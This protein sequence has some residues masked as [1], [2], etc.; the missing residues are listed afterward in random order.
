VRTR[1]R[2][3]LLCAKTMFRGAQEDG[4]QPPPLVLHV[5]GAFHCAHGLGI[6]EALPRYSSASQPCDSSTLA[7]SAAAELPGSVW[8]P[9][10]DSNMSGEY[11]S[12]Q[13]G[14]PPPSGGGDGDSD[15]YVGP[16][17]CPAGVLSLVCWPASVK[18]TLDVVE[19]G[20]VPQSLGSMADWVII[21]EETYGEE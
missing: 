9:M 8:L 16:K 12:R 15:D 17:R 4:E 14:H 10:D 1:F 20:R 2:T 21:T 13:A 5:C 6:P 19:G 7:A 3:G 18:G 11:S